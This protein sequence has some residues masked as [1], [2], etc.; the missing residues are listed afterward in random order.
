MFPFFRAFL[1][2]QLLLC[3]L[4]AIVAIVVL[5][6]KFN[7]NAILA[8][9]MAALGLGLVAGMNPAVIAESF[10]AGVGKALGSVTGVIVLG[11]MLGKMLAESGGAEVVAA[12]IVGWFG[13]KRA[14]WAILVAAIA[15]G[16]PV[17]FSVGFMLLLPIVFVISRSNKI[18][19]MKLGIPLAAG[20]SAMHACV[21]PHPG[22][23]IVIKELHADIGKTILYS[24]IIAIPMAILGGPIYGQWILKRVRFDQP[25]AEANAVDEK[26][27]APVAP[28]GFGLTVVTMFLPIVLMLM[29]GLADV[30]LSP[31][32]TLRGWC[33]FFGGPFISMLI[34]VLF[35]F[36]SFGFARGMK[37]SEILKHS[38]DCLGP[39]AATLLVVGAGGGFNQILKE[40]GV[41]GAIVRFAEG[42]QL[43]PLVM[44]WLVASLIRVAVGS[45][46]VAI[47]TAVGIVGPMAMG[48]AGV[49]KELLVVALGAGSLIFSHVNDGGFWIVKEFFGISVSQT[50]KTWSVGTTIA[51]VAGLLL[52]LLL[53]AVL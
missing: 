52:T 10:E 12:R 48:H 53:Q 19:L 20:L 9:A 21:P 24:L 3:A 43:P 49:N 38:N 4:A 30:K 34:A 6:G 31:D 47:T 13:V 26:K 39:V 27:A 45:S 25:T 33:V 37:S 16:M 36:Y 22:P 5:I 41:A 23:M 46:T 1:D 28:P 32:S 7:L 2:T 42:A 51:S 50:F 44:G 11:A 15:I 40:C 8:L 14:D 18:P 35:S 17:F 29:K